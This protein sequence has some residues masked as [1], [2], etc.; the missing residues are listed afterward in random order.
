MSQPGQTVGPDP[1]PAGSAVYSIRILRPFLLLVALF[2]IEVVVFTVLLDG[3]ELSSHDFLIRA[4]RV[5]G[6]RLLRAFIC[7]A[8]VFFGFAFLKYR[9][10]PPS[11]GC[12][13]LWGLLGAHFAA[14]WL[15]G[16][17]SLI[18]FSNR[19]PGG[20]SAPWALFWLVSGAMTLLLAALAFIPAAAWMG[21]IRETGR[22]W[23]FAALAAGLVAFG[24]DY[25]RDL[26]VPLTSLTLRIVV[27]ML[28]PFVK[29]QIV[30]HV[31]PT[32]VTRHFEAE[33]APECSG[34]EGMGLIIAFGAIWLWLY[35]KECRFP[36]A[37]L[38][39]PAGVIA[40]YLLN[41]VRIAALILIGEAGAPEIA[42]GGFHS[43]AGWIAFTAASFAFS[44][45]ATRIPW[46]AAQPVRR[47]HARTKE[48]A[49]TE[50][51]LVPFLAI[52]AA[53]ILAMAVSAGFEWLYGLR[54]LAAAGALF[55]YRASYRRLDWRF[56]WEGVAAGA[57][58]FGVWIGLDRVGGVPA[59]VMPPLLAAASPGLRG[60]WIAI[61]ALAAVATVPIAEEL[62]FRGFL[63][64]RLTAADFESVQWNAV[65]WTAIGVSSILFGIMHSGRAVAGILAGLVFAAVAIRRRRIGEAVAAHAVANA[66]IAGYVLLFGHWELW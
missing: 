41:S 10:S 45:A 62:A 40:I 23:I 64:R 61:R 19:F 50:A 35:R 38:L 32:I 9:V 49:P 44:Y 60:L 52:L 12:M 28:S 34:F 13:P 58:V 15:F 25:A 27:A 47:A 57:L 8:A 59:G 14:L 16:M 53:G 56:G 17:L 63:L 22:L 2:A 30:Q 26:W 7:F 33:I 48:T 3:A 18:L 6:P 4:I 55:H 31:F 42:N 20:Q 39:L 21:M 65:S 1:F 37:L 66:L 5:A 11:A 29:A 54:L 24:A 36:Q 51:Y 46:I 43:Q